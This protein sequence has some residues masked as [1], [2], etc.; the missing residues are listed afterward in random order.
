[1]YIVFV[2]TFIGDVFLAT[3]VV[4]LGEEITVILN[5]ANE[6]RGDRVVLQL[7][8]GGGTVTRYGLASA[9]LLRFKDAGLPLTICIDEVATSGGYMVASVADEIIASPFAVV[10]SVGVIATI[11]NFS[12]RLQREG[13]LVEDITAGKKKRTLTPYNK[14]NPEDRNKMKADVENILVLFKKF[15]KQNR[16]K[17]HVDEIATGETWQVE[18]AIKLGLVDS[19]QT[20]DAYLLGL[21]DKQFAEILNISIKQAVPRFSDVLE[22]EQHSSLSIFVDSEGVTATIQKW[23][24]NMIVGAL[25]LVWK[26]QTQSPSSLSLPTIFPGGNEQL[27]LQR[28]IDQAQTT[29]TNVQFQQHLHQS[30]IPTIHSLRLIFVLFLSFII[31]FATSTNQLLAMKYSECEPIERVLAVGTQHLVYPTKCESVVLRISFHLAKQHGR[32]IFPSEIANL[33]LDASDQEHPFYN[34]LAHGN[35][36]IRDR[37]TV[38]NYGSLES[39]LEELQFKSNLSLIQPS[40]LKII[41]PIIAGD[42]EMPQEIRVSSNNE[43]CK[44]IISNFLRYFNISCD[45]RL[46][47][48]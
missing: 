17:F 35:R 2:L 43:T 34:I 30:S 10:G 29:A 11:P 16:P 46:N 31:S 32:W 48:I 15:L 9:Q 36:V 6:D 22:D 40:F 7:N 12:E 19:L 42:V 13:V 44:Y 41:Q 37:G 27:R 3:Q 26:Q 39:K 20:S 45:D 18:D 1:M 25:K 28:S 5:L 23:L 38:F 24:A 14:S 47:D 33:N 21:Q 8:F 4:R